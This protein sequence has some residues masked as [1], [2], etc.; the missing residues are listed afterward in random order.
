M[1]RPASGTADPNR[2]QALNPEL[3]DQTIRLLSAAQ[4]PI[5]LIL[6][7]KQ[8]PLGKQQRMTGLRILL[9]SIPDVLLLASEPAVALD[10]VLYGASAASVGVTSGLR[11]PSPPPKGGGFANGYVTGMLLRELWEHRSP[12]TYADWYRGRPEPVCVL[13]PEQRS[14]AS[15]DPGSRDKNIILRHNL[16]TWLAVLDELRALPLSEARSHLA[17]ERREALDRNAQLRP[18]AT[19]S[20]FDPVLRQL[21]ALDDGMLPQ[22][23]L[24]R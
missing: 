19:L 11:Q 22:S 24:G 21:V 17:Q 8:Q 4:R 6:L 20:E 18:Q 7:S 13:C 2:R 23:L 5:A 1:R 9:A 16:R 15:Y 12:V 10:T 14:F 3:L